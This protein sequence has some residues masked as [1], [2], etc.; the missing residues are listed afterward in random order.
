[1]QAGYLVPGLFVSE[2][3]DY[4]TSVINVVLILSEQLEQ[5][6]ERF[7][8][9]KELGAPEVVVL[10]EKHTLLAITAQLEIYCSLLKEELR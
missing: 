1:M 5:R 7:N 4:I 9:F 2:R 10:M 3:R 8:R 6:W